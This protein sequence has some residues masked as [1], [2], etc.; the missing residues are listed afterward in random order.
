MQQV[1]RE[2]F[3]KRY[4]RLP[5]ET[6]NLIAGKVRAWEHPTKNDDAIM[7]VLSGSDRNEDTR[8]YE[9]A[10]RLRAIVAQ[11]TPGGKYANFGARTQDEQDSLVSQFGDNADYMLSPGQRQNHEALRVTEL[12]SAADTNYEPASG[13]SQAARYIGGALGPAIDAVRSVTTE[14]GVYDPRRT[15]EAWDEASLISQPDGKYSYAAE[16]WQRG[17]GDQGSMTDMNVYTPEGRA[18]YGAYDPTT[19]AEVANA[20]QVNTAFPLASAYTY[21]APVR[22]LPMLLGTALAGEDPF[23]LASGLNDMRQGGNRI[24]PV[25]PRGMD[26]AEFERQTRSLKDADTRMEGWN[27]AYFGPKFADAYNATLGAVLPKASRTYLSPGGNTLFG[28]PG[29]SL[30]DPLNLAF[31]VAGGPV[32]GAARGALTGTAGAAGN[33][34]IRGLVRMASRS[35]DD[36]VEET[37]EDSAFVGPATTGIKDFFAPEQNNLMMGNKDPNDADYDQ[38]LERRTQEALDARRAAAEARNRSRPASPVAK[39]MS[40]PSYGGRSPL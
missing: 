19:I 30:S 12:L 7:A 6:W 39:P 23:N 8:E 35:A 20:S 32:Y 29:E 4:E 37:I 33:H 18:K 3:I 2:Q 5:P 27:S 40:G 14:P 24:T 28:V 10:R 16:R 9:S 38:Q 26:A 34:M 15:G 21:T 22:E 25:I 13:F 1:S 36:A 11:H 17:Q 31:N